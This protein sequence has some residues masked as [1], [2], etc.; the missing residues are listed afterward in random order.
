MQFPRLNLQYEANDCPYSIV[1]DGTGYRLALRNDFASLRNR[2]FGR[3]RAARLSAAAV[4]VLS[5]IAYHE[6]LSGDDV[7]RLRGT[8]SG[9][10]LSQLVGRQLLR[11][12]RSEGKTSKRRYFITTR[13]LKLFHLRSLEDLPRSDDLQRQ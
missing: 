8:P 12:E 6:P 5:L 2:F 4:E 13:F 1:S 10:I 11:I 7:S 9:H 3:I